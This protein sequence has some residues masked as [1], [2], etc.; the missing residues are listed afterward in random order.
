MHALLRGR[1]R[2]MRLWLARRAAAATDAA[3][4]RTTPRQCFADAGFS[5]HMLLCHADVDMALWCLKSFTRF[6]ALSPPIV[7]H[8]DGSLSAD[9]AALLQAHLAR[10]TVVARDAADRRADAALQAY[11]ICRRMRRTA[12]FHCALK[13]FDPWL[14]APGDRIALIDSDVLFFRRPN[15]FLACAEDG[16]ACFSAD[17]QD[18]YA[19]DPAA[20][21]DALGIDL[22]DRVNAGLMALPRTAFDLDLIERY[23]AAFP[24]AIPDINRH[25]QT[26][27]ALLLSRAGARRLGAGYQ[28]GQRPLGPGTVSH[29]FVNDGSRR[30]FFTHGVRRLRQQG[31]IPRSNG[32]GTC[33]GR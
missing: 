32:D 6:A 16:T 21:R 24:A 4:I 28:I 3:W 19:V 11:P 25:E 7:I 17:Y 14:F 18:A 33:R 27:Y 22:F 5:I 10:C 26:L 23:F 12:G 2:D 30:R 31:A 1:R 8:D 9:D 13:L 29:H 15:E 20:L